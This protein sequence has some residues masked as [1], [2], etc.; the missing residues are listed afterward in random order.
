MLAALGAAGASSVSGGE[1][2]VM[3]GCP[4]AQAEEAL[5]SLVVANLLGAPAGGRY[6]L[7]A[8][9]RAYARE[10]AQAVAVRRHGR[11]YMRAG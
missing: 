1:V 8:L 6:R 4:E 11:S 3:V 2:A 10:R 7:D 5:D 9:L